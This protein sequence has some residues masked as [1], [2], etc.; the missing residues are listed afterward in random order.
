MATTSKEIY[1]DKVNTFEKI[2]D[3]T[4]NAMYTMSI[5]NVDWEINE[6]EETYN[7]HR[8]FVLSSQ[9]FDV[10]DLFDEDI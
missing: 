10:P 6:S 4:D 5:E 3:N 1:I 8:S 7:L 9:Y 2:V